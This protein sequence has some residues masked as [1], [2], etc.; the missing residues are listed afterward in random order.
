VAYE[1]QDFI[2]HREYIGSPPACGGVRIARLFSFLRCVGFTLSLL[3]K[4]PK[5]LDIQSKGEYDANTPKMTTEYVYL[6]YKVSNDCNLFSPG[7]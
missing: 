3:E 4:T 5:N 1:N 6:K 7:S 2:T